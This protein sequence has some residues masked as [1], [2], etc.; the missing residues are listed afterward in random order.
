MIK[1]TT[2]LES[3]IRYSSQPRF[4]LEVGIIQ[5]TKMEQSVKIDALLQQ[6]DE[7]KK[8]LNSGDHSPRK[9]FSVNVSSPFSGPAFRAAQVRLPK[10]IE[11][12]YIL[13][14]KSRT[15]LKLSLVS[16][17]ADPVPQIQPRR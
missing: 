5:M 11:A 14:R 8:K 1:L 16:P 7:M 2:D 17:Q 12:M 13:S 9:P 3:S 10:R 4:K 6:L 15:L